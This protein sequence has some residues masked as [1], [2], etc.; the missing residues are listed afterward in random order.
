MA[1]ETTGGAPGPEET[2]EAPAYDPADELI[3]IEDFMKVKLRVAEV[4]AAEPHPNADKLLRL[5][6]RVG[7][8]R[9]QICAG[10]RQHYEPEALVGKR[11][12]VVDNLQPATLRGEVS[13][14][15]LLAATDGD[16]VVLLTTDRPDV[17]PGSP[18]R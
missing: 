18:V 15:M 6:I 2:P 3:T 7:E 5:Q 11:L 12:I 16:D 14:G 13:Q 1:D 9:K 10:I 4:L 17:A 8:R